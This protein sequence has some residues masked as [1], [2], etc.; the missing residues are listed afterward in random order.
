M[1]CLNRLHR[2]IQAIM[3][4]RQSV[5]PTITFDQN[6]KQTGKLKLLGKIEN[7]ATPCDVYIL[8]EVDFRCSATTMIQCMN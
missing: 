7:H 5:Y 8:K 6:P 2:E 4:R 1:Q 3:C